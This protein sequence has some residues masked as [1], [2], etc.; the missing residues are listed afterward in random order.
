MVLKIESERSK[1]SDYVG[2]GLE[3]RL[4]GA[5]RRQRFIDQQGWKCVGF[6]SPK[7]TFL[8]YANQRVMFTITLFSNLTTH[9]LGYPIHI[10]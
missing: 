1:L 4:K 3:A 6:F 5:D 10:I 8:S 7:Y 2:T 9:D